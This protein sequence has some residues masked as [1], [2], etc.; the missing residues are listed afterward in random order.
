[1]TVLNV[2]PRNV[3][4]TLL[5][6]EGIA[7]LFLVLIINQFVSIFLEYNMRPV[8]SILKFN[9][10]FCKNDSTYILFTFQR[11]IER[12]ENCVLYVARYPLALL[13]TFETTGRFQLNSGR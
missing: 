11:K 4:V 2:L 9:V 13:T 5:F 10:E 3:S 7:S 12:R 8:L 6:D 1:M